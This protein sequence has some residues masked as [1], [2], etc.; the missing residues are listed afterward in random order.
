VP[1]DANSRIQVEADGH[2]TILMPLR[3]FGAFR[4]DFVLVPEAI[5]TGQ[6]V[7][8]AGAPV[9]GARVIGVEYEDALQTVKITMGDL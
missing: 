6:V 1:A 7:T 4:Y 5:L 9:A 8:E 3:V 2:G